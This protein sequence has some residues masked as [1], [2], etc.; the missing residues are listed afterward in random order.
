MYSCCRP[1]VSNW[2]LYTGR[3]LKENVSAGRRLKWKRLCGPHCGAQNI[4]YRDVLTYLKNGL[5]WTAIDCEMRK[6]LKSANII[7]HLQYLQYWSL[8]LFCSLPDIREKY[9]KQ[10]KK[11]LNQ[12]VQI[13]NKVFP[14][15]SKFLINL[16][17]R[18]PKHVYMAQNVLI[19]TKR[20]NISWLFAA[21]K[22]QI[23]KTMNTKKTSNSYSHLYEKLET[24][25]I[26]YTVYT[27]V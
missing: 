25:K 6:K 5:V 9:A 4:K 2:K 1:G 10:Q 16:K 17:P 14:R 27:R 15:Y 22:L 11:I 3:I 8:I 21:F 12:F 23:V 24:L 7:T 18:I 13:I 26:L 19:K 20:N